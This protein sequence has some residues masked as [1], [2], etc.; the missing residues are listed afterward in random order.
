M[1][2]RKD[3]QAAI[4]RRLGDRLPCRPS[5]ILSELRADE[6]F[7]SVSDFEIRENIVCMVAAGIIKSNSRLEIYMEP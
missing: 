4:I 1:V 6:M 3:I 5:Q 2:T 7:Q